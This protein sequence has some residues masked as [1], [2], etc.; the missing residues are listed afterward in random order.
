[1][2]KEKYFSYKYLIPIIVLFTCLFIFST[3]S[4]AL[5]PGDFGSANNGPPDG[6]V[7]FE[8][9]M[10][11]ALAYGSTSADDNWNPDCD[12]AGSNCPTTTDGVIDFEDLMIF[13][14][15]YG[16]RDKVTG[17]K[18]IAITTPYSL[19]P[20]IPPHSCFIYDWI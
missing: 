6:V 11:F 7:D 12:I 8:D 4:L 2:V 9:L 17:V 10:I 16:R 15:N 1:M 5:I 19:E 14:M 13:A 18:G 20:V 3:I